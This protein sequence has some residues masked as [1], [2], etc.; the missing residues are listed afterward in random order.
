MVWIAA[1]FEFYIG[2]VESDV[3]D[4]YVSL[5]IERNHSSHR[6]LPVLRRIIRY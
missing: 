1:T 5:Q 4:A 6:R 3:A 2:G